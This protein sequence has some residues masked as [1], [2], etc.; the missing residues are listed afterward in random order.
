VREQLVFVLTRREI[1]HGQLRL[2]RGCD[3]PALA[4]TSV[5]HQAE[6]PS[7]APQRCGFRVGPGRLEGTAVTFGALAATL[8]T[9]LGR[10]VVVDSPAFERFDIHV[11]WNPAAANPVAALR[12]AVITGLLAHGSE[13]YGI[14]TVYLRAKNIAPQ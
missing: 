11:S 7:P 4:V 8:S 1:S 3:P 12:A 14:S 5:P 9:P 10:V 6:E 13:M 2:S